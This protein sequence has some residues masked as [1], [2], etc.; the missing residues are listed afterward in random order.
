MKSSHSNLIK[1]S[2]RATSTQKPPS[3]ADCHL[4]QPRREGLQR[5]LSMTWSFHMGPIKSLSTYFLHEKPLNVQIKMPRL[6]YWHSESSESNEMLRSVLEPGLSETAPS[7]HWQQPSK[8]TATL[9]TFSHTS[10]LSSCTFTACWHSG[11]NLNQESWI[12]TVKHS[13][14]R[15]LNKDIEKGIG[16]ALSQTLVMTLLF[17]DASK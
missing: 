12:W 4:L 11:R 7:F 2:I 10:F 8:A 14:W 13:I 5:A 17:G 1:R 15:I 9:W 16:Q 3:R 6:P